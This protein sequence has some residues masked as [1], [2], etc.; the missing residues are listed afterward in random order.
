MTDKDA[1]AGLEALMPEAPD[2]SGLPVTV[3]VGSTPLFG[4]ILIV[5]GGLMPIAM[6]LILTLIGWIAEVPPAWFWIKTAFAVIPLLALPWGWWILKSMSRV[7]I[8]PDS[9]RYERV[10]PLGRKVWEAPLAEYTGMVMREVLPSSRAVER[11]VHFAVEM[12]HPNPRRIA[13]L[14]HTKDKALAQVM[15]DKI[16]GLTGLAVRD[17]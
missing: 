1:L 5:A 14:T 10:T 2:F 4:V 13:R 12:D 9:V 16:A 11:V 8:G 17:P 7:R 6:F 15:L 3:Q